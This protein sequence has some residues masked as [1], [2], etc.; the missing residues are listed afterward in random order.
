MRNI[1]IVI[2]F[3]YCFSMLGQS[4]KGY[5]IDINGHYQLNESLV[6]NGFVDIYN[7]FPS[8][9]SKLPKYLVYIM[10][11]DLDEYTTN[12][13]LLKRETQVSLTQDLNGHILESKEAMYAGLKGV[14]L[15]VDYSNENLSITGCVFMSVIDGSLYRVLVMIPTEEYYEKYYPEFKEI[16]E[17]F[18]LT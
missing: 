17:S 13:S 5:A 6:E 15:K 8:D 7:V 11:N 14:E 3:M 12:T 18:K 1:L 2:Q 9:T 4:K 16:A 10:R